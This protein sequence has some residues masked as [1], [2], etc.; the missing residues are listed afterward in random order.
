MITTSLSLLILVAYCS[1]PSQYNN[2]TQNWNKSIS[3]AIKT[4]TEECFSFDKFSLDNDSLIYITTRT[5]NY[6][7]LSDDF[8]GELIFFTEINNNSY[9]RK[10]LLFN[11][12]EKL[13]KDS[14]IIEYN[15]Y[16]LSNVIT[17]DDKKYIGVAKIRVEK[18]EKD[19]FL[20]IAIGLT[21][22]E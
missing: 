7:Y 18:E 9:Y 1:K 11:S 5:E 22:L 12:I 8:H 19:C 20:Q 14:L 16:K 13:K 10:K 4:G 17:H 21:S 3:E 6:G 2:L 15:I